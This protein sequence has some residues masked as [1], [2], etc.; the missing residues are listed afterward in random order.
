MKLRHSL[1]TLLHALRVNMEHVSEAQAYF[2]DI[3]INIEP[4]IMFLRPCQVG[5]MCEL[6]VTVWFKLR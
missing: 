6:K 2:V 4:S 3:H 1:T 5:W